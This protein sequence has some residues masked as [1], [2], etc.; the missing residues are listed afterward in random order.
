MKDEIVHLSI[1][2]RDLDDFI[3]DTNQELQ[4]RKSSLLQQEEKVKITEIRIEQDHDN[5]I[6]MQNRLLQTDDEVI[7]TKHEI[8]AYSTFQHTTDKSAQIT[9]H[10]AN[11]AASLLS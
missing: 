3:A 4:A 8:E 1:L 7:A 2:V 6:Q 10:E 11:V 9:S 5:L